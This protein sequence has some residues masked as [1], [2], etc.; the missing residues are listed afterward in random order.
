MDPH[1]NDRESRYAELM[2]DIFGEC[3][4]VLR[5]PHGRLVF[6]FHHWNPKGWSALTLALQQA[7]FRLLNYAVVHAESPISV[8]I[9]NMNALTHDAIL[10]LAPAGAHANGAPEW[11]RPS[12][13]DTSGS[14]A[15]CAGCA[16]LLGWLLRQNL[17]VTAVQ[18]VWLAALP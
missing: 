17:P 1:N 9:S 15:F 13:I 6:T 5:R 2:A 4:R 16:E 14:A 8:H 11:E 12:Q 18:D 7:G 3:A 10:V